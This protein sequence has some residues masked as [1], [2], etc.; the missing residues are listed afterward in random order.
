MTIAGLQK[1]TN[2][3]LYKSPPERTV[4]YRRAFASRNKR[5]TFHSG[6]AAR[7]GETNINIGTPQQR[8]NLLPS[9]AAAIL[10]ISKMTNHHNNHI[11]IIFMGT[12]EFA[13]ASLKALVEKGFKI[14]AVITA[15]DKPAGRGMKLNESP[16][17]KYAFEHGLKILQPEKLRNRE[18]LE[19]LRSLQ[20][21]LQV[22]V[23]F[24]MLPEIVWSMPPMGTINV[25]ASLLPQYRGAAPINWAIINGENETG[26]TTFRLKHEIDTGDILLQEKILIGESETAGELH[27]KLKV[28][29]GG[30]LVKTVKGLADGSLKEMAQAAIGTESH[31]RQSEIL[32][33]APKIFTETCKIDWTKT[34]AEIHNLIRGLSP[35]PGAF[36]ILRGKMLKIYRS[37]KEISKP[38]LKPGE[39]ESDHKNFLKFSCVNGY[40]HLKEVQLEGKKKMMIEDFLKGYRFEQASS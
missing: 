15:P 8:G 2:E 16:V 6:Q 31:R 29:G 22:V 34:T 24:R 32:K 40:I 36:S 21:D 23:A 20:A 39:C 28:I 18:F 35:F 9:L 4:R 1:S 11:R 10:H 13:V 5:D 3:Y 37:E 38:A 17:K 30:L 25:H 19:E 26:V 14:V 27:D 7:S 33:H 12:P